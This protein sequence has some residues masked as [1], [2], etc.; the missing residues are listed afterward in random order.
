[1]MATAPLIVVAQLLP[2]VCLKLIVITHIMTHS[3][4]LTEDTRADVYS[5]LRNPPDIPYEP[6]TSPRWLNKELKF[7]MSTLHTD[8]KN[9]MLELLHK[10]LRDCKEKRLLWVIAFIGLL[11][12][13][14]VTESMQVCVRCK[15]E[16]DKQM[17]ALAKDDST[18][19]SEVNRM[20]ERLDFLMRIFWKKYHVA[21]HKGGKAKAEFNPVRDLKDR[22][23]LDGPAQIF[24][25]EVDRVI[26]DYR[27]S[28]VCCAEA[29][30]TYALDPFLESRRNLS[31]PPLTPNEPRTSRLVAKFLLSF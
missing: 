1:M 29:G 2:R 8:L 22:G 17:G 4:T 10:N 25:R 30:L 16:T 28:S 27:K 9:H 12:L 24:A 7:L 6:G 3:L 13:S 20:D 21:E 26:R 23:S 19:K 31:G 11:T 14:M 18:A 5:R 15:E